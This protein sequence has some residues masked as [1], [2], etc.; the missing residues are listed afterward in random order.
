ISA[1]PLH[2]EKAEAVEF[3]AL[4]TSEITNK[5]LK[6]IKL[7]RGTIIGAI[8]REDKILIPGGASIIKPGDLVILVTLRSAIPKVEKILT[9]KLDYFE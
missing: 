1:T 4:E 5:P 8:I 6:D 2:D 3:I 9:V 7:P